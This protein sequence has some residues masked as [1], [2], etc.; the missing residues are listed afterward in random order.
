MQSLIQNKAAELEKKKEKNAFE[1]A[2]DALNPK[3]DIESALLVILATMERIQ[4]TFCHGLGHTSSE[5]STKKNVDMSV[6]RAPALRIL[7]GSLK[8]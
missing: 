7:W 6:R 4:C 1:K 8:G 3:D 2:K 5:C